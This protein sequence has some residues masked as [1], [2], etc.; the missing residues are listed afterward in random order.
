MERKSAVAFIDSRRSCHRLDLNISRYFIISNCK[1]HSKNC[2]SDEVNFQL[3]GLIKLR[4]K[5]A[6]YLSLLVKSA[7]TVDALHL[8]HLD[9]SKLWAYSIKSCVCVCVCIK[10]CCALCRTPTSFCSCHFV[11]LHFVWH[12]PKA[13]SKTNKLSNADLKKSSFEN[14]NETKPN[15]TLKYTAFLW[16]AKVRSFS[17]WNIEFTV[18]IYSIFFSVSF[19]FFFFPFRC[20]DNF[21]FRFQIYLVQFSF[22]YL[23]IAGKKMLHF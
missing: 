16:I 9:D 2:H 19:L 3:D 23:F 18:G 15:C 7:W 12:S 13:A 14:R 6:P 10:I 11:R 4:I 22:I 20:N 17:S 1:G 5:Y 21:L 8:Y